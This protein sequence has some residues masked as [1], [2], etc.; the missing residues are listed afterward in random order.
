MAQFL[1]DSVH[2]SYPIG[3]LLLWRTR[4]RLDTD[5]NLGPYL[6][7]P[8]RDGFPIDYVLDGQQRL[9]CL[10]AAL[11]TSIQAT[12]ESPWMDIYFDIDAAPAAQ[13]SQFVAL[14]PGS[15]DQQRHFPLRVVLDPIA[16]RR[17]TRPLPDDVVARLD[18]MAQAFKEYQIPVQVIDTDDRSKVAHIFER[19]NRTG[20]PL[21]NFQLLAAWTWNAD[22]DLRRRYNALCDELEPFGFADLRDD[23][24]LL[25][26]CCAAVISN[27]ASQQAIMSLRGE[28]VRNRFSE[29]ENGVRGALDFLR[30]SCHVESLRVMPYPAM[31]APLARFFATPGGS[32]TLRTDAQRATLLR[33]LWR[34]L[35]SRRYSSGVGYALQDDIRFA[36]RLQDDPTTSIPHFDYSI[37]RD[38]FLQNQFLLTSVNTK[39]FVL[40]LAD[41][42]PRSFLSGAPVDLRQ[43]LLRCHKTEFHH[44]FP[45]AYLDGL[46]VPP[47]QTNCLAN[48]CFLSKADNARIGATPP[49]QYI[50]LLPQQ[51]RDAI[52]RSSLVPPNSLT[53]PFSAFLEQRA[54]LLVTQVG[55]L[56]G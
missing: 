28:V 36:G 6:L 11:Q 21:D 5:R 29:V 34:C 45:R 15:V 35:F 43:A 52:L 32:A 55:A 19:V 27:D 42:A 38:F 2:K 4:E 49:S 39:T 48:F 30:A 18:R 50:T 44:I 23:P 53:A 33:W 9:T 51:D 22:F 37:S 8:P 12:A 14:A 13:D 1:L 17:A 47:E 7:P 16:Y 56:C 10:F 31:L 25:L 41:S 54:A 3:A 46:S 40:L 24:N 26:R 20:V